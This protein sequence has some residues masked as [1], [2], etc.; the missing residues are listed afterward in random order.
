MKDCPYMSRQALFGNSVAVGEL[1][2]DLQDGVLLLQLLEIISNERLPR[3]SRGRLRV[4]KIEN[5]N[6]ALKFL[7][8]KRVKLESIGAEDIVDGNPRLT[9]GLIWTIILRFQIQD[10]KLEEEESNEKRSAKEALLIWCQRKTAGYRSCKVDNFTTSW[11]NGLAFNALIHAHRPDL[12]NYDRLNPSEHIH[13]LN[14]AFSVAQERLGISRLLDAED[15]DIAKPDEKSIMTYVAAYYH[16]FAKMKSEQTGSKRIAKIMDFQIEID[17]MKT[18]YER[19]VEALLEWISEKQEQLDSRQFPNTLEGVQRETTKFKQYR[20]IEKPPKYNERGLIE[21]QFFDI[22]TKLRANNQ[23]PYVPPEGRMLNDVEKAWQQLESSEHAREIALREETSRQERLQQLAEKFER[24]A[25]LRETYVKDMDRVLD[26]RYFVVKD[27]A[28]VEA[29]IKKHEAISADLLPRKER[30]TMLSQMAN[31][32]WQENYHRKEEVKG[33]E[34]SIVQRWSHLLQLVERRGQ[35]LANF[36]DLMDM[37]RE[38]ESITAEIKEIEGQ[39][40]SEDY[41]KHLFGVEDLLQK[42]QLMEAHVKSLGQRVDRVNIK[43]NGFISSQHAESA[44]IQKKLEDVNTNYDRLK[45]KSGIRRTKLEDGLNHYEFLRDTEEE[46]GWVM[47][48]QRIAKSVVTGKDLHSVLSQQQKH[49]ALEAEMA[50]RHPQLEAVCGRGQAL[51]DSKH[52]HRGEISLRVKGLQEKWDRLKDLAVS[53]RIRLEQAVLAHQY[54]TDGNEAESWMREK[55]PLVCSEDYGKDVQSAQSLLQRH[56]YLEEEIRAYESGI[57]KLGEQAQQMIDSGTMNQLQSTSSPSMN[58][59]LEEDQYL[60]E[61]VEVPYEVE[62]EKTVEREAVREVLEDRKVP[63]VKAMYKYSGKGMSVDRGQILVLTSKTNKDWWCV[64][65]PDGVE[66]YVPANYVKEV[67]GKVTSVHFDRDNLEERQQ[68]ISATYRRLVKLAQARRRY[69]EDS[70]QLFG[71]YRECDEFESWMQDQEKVMKSVESMKDNVEA[72]KRKFENLMTALAANTGRMKK[73]DQLADEFVKTGHSQ[74]KPVRAR[75]KELK[76]RWERLHQLQRDKEKL[77]EGASSIEL[78]ERTC[79]DTKEW[80]QEKFAALSNDDLGN[81]VKGVKA[82]QRQ[83]Q[84]L[85]RELG[86]VEDKISKL[87]LLATAVKTAHPS[88]NAPIALKEER[89]LNMWQQLK[90]KASLRKA[91]LAQSHDTQKFQEENKDLMS[92]LSSVKEQLKSEELARD[93]LHAEELIK[94]HQEL[95]D[96]IA[97]HQDSFKELQR[98]GERLLRKAPTNRDLRRKVELLKQEQQ[99]L[100]AAWNS[101]DEQLHDSHELQLFHREADQID[102]VTSS[103]EAFLEFDELGSTVDSVQ[104]L[105]KRHEEF[106]HTLQVQ[107]DRINSL[108]DIANKLLQAKHYAGRQ[109]DQK[110]NQVV[111]RRKKVKG[112]AKD[113]RAALQAS[114]TY[115]EFLRD[116]EELSQWIR[117][118]Y[119]A[120]TDESYRDLTNLQGKLQ[121]HEAFE[122]ELRANTER[123]DR[124]NQAGKALVAERHYARKEIQETLRDL[125]T[126][127]ADLYDRCVENMMYLLLISCIRHLAKNV[128]GLGPAQDRMDE[129]EVLL[130]VQDLGKDLRGARNL[131]KKHQELEQE[132]S[133]QAEKIQSISLQAPMLR[134]RGELED[135]V[136]LQEF[137]RDLD[138][139][140]RWIRDHMPAAT[141]TDYGK[142]L[143]AALKLQKKHQKLE[144][145]VTGHQPVI[146]KVLGEG[147]DLIEAQHY[148]VEEI[149]GKCEELSSAWAELVERSEERRAQLRLSVEGQQFLADA[150]EVESWVAEK[151]RLASSTDYGKD[152]D[153]AEK[154]I[155]K[156]KALE[157]DL[158]TYKGL[159]KQLQHK[160]QKLK[161][162]GHVN[163]K[164]IQDRHSNLDGQMKSL[165]TLMGDRSVHLEESKQLFA[166]A[167]ET[168]DLQE[169]I[170]EHLMMAASEDYGQDYEHLQVLLSKFED[171]KHK[172]G[173][174]QRRFQQCER[175]A[176]RLVEMN[177]SYS[178]AIQERQEGL[179]ESWTLLQE[180]TKAR[181]EKLVAAEEIHRFNR[182]AAEAMSRIQEKYAAI[183][184]D[185]GRDLNTVQS[186][187]RRHEGFEN[188]LVALEAQLQVL[189]D[190][191]ARLQ[192]LFP[193]GNAEQIAEQQEVL[194]SSWN[195]LQERTVQRREE[196]QQA[197]DFQKFLASVRDLLAWSGETTRDMLAEEAGRDVA[198]TDE[199]RRQHAQHKVEIDAREDSFGAIVQAGEMMMDAGHY[200]KDEIQE[201]VQQVVEEKGKLLQTW[202]DHRKHLDDAYNQQVFN[203]DAQQLDR[204]SSEQ[205]VH[206]RSS[207]LG[208]TVEQ[209]ERLIKRHEAFQKLLA[210][211][212]DKVVA[213][214]ELAARLLAEEHFD[215]TNIKDTLVRVMERRANVKEA[216]AERRRKLGDSMLYVLFNRDV[217]EVEGWISEKLQIASDESYRDSTSLQ[218]KMAKL[219][220]HQAFEAEITANRERINRIKKQGDQLVSK[221]HHASVEIKRR[222][223]AVLRAWQELLQASAARGKGL[224]EARDILEF[225]QQ[226]DQV[227]QWVKEK[228]LLVSAGELGRDYEHCL[229]L[230]KKL[231]DF[232]SD[233]TVDDARIKSVNK[234][235]DRLVL[236]A[237]LDTKD[238]L[239]KRKTMNERWTNLQEALKSYRVRLAGALEVHAFNRDCDDTND[240]IK[241]KAKAMSSEDYG[242]DLASV[243]SL[244]RRHEDMERDMTAIVA[245][246]E[247]LGTEAE[248]LVHKQPNMAEAIQQKQV[249]V[250]ENWEKLNDHAEARKEKLAASYQL[251]KFL[252]EFKDLNTWMS[253]MVGRMTSGELAKDVAGA[254]NMLELHNE[255]KVEIEGR[256]ESFKTLSTFGKTLISEGHYASNDIQLHLENLADAQAH[257]F[258]TWE[259]RNILL[260]QCYDLQMFHEYAEQGDTWLGGKEAF[261]HNEDV[262]D[263]LESVESLNRKHEGFEKTLETQIEKLEVLQ[264]FAG[265]LTEAGHYQSDK[266]Q[267][268]CKQVMERKEQLKQRASGRKKRLEESKALHQFLRN[269]Y[270]VLG[271]INEKMQT[272]LDECYRDPTNLQSKLQKH[273]A[274]EAELSANKGRV[275]GVKREGEDLIEAD[276]FAAAEIQ[277][278]VVEVETNWEKLTDATQVRRDRLQD[279]HQ[280]QQFFH[281]VDDLESWLGEVEVQLGSQDLG[282]DLIS[283]LE[284]EI[285][286]QQTKVE[287]ILASASAYRDKQHFLADNIQERATVITDR[288]NG[289][290]EPMQ[291]RRDNLEDTLVLQQFYRDVEDELAWVREKEPLATSTDLGQNLTSVQSLQKKHQA[292]EAE[293]SSHEPLIDAVLNTGQHL[294]GGEHYAAADI[295]YHLK[296]GTDINISCPVYQQ[297][298]AEVSEAESWM[299]DRRPLLTSTE[300][301]KD[302][303]SAQALLKKLDT[304]ERDLE[305]F[306]ST[307]DSLAVLAKS[308]VDKKHYAATKIK[309][310]QAQAQK[311]FAAL[312]ESAVRRRA[313]LVECH[314]LYQFYREADEVCAWI[315]EKGTVAASEDYGKDLEHVQI[316]QKKF[317]DFVQQVS[318]SE[319]RV[320]SV[321]DLGKALCDEQHTDAAAIIARCSE[322]NQ[323][324][325]ELKEMTQSRQEALDGARQV[326]TFDRDCEETKSWIHEKEM[327]LSSEDYGHDLA[328]VQAAVRRHEGVE[329]D[330]A[331]LG[332]QVDSINREASRLNTILPDARHHID[333]RREDVANVWNALLNSAL[334]RKDRLQQA[335]KLQLYFN[336]F[337]ELMAWTK[338]MK[339]IISRPEEAKDVSGV[340]AIIA[341]HVEHRAEIDG[342]LDNF[343]KFVQAGQALIDKGHFLAG[344]GDGLTDTVR[345][346]VERLNTALEGLLQLWEERRQTYENMLDAQMFKREAEQADAWLDLR[347]SVIAD[348]DYGDSVSAVEELLKKQEDFEKTLAAQEEKFSALNRLTMTEQRSEQHKANLA[349]LQKEEEQRKEQ[350]R[351][352]EMRKREQERI[353]EERRLEQERRRAREEQERKEREA[354]ERLVAEQNARLEAEANRLEQERNGQVTTV[355]EPN[356]TPVPTPVVAPR[357]PVQAPAPVVAPRTPVQVPA[358]VVAPRTPV[359]VPA[360]EE[361][362]ARGTPSHVTIPVAA[363]RTDVQVPMQVDAKRGPSQIPAQ[364]VAQDRRRAAP[365]APPKVHV[366]VASKVT[367]PPVSPREE[368]KEDMLDAA[369]PVEVELPSETVVASAAPMAAAAPPF[370]KTAKKED[371]QVVKV[372][373]L[374]NDSVRSVVSKKGEAGKK[375]PDMQ[376]ER[377]GTLERKQELQP[378][379]KRSTVR[380]WKSYYT[381]LSGPLLCFYKDQKDWTQSSTAGPSIQLQGATCEVAVDYHKKKH[382]FRLRPCDGSEYL[383][384]AKS[385]L[386]MR[387][388]ISKVQIQ[389]NLPPPAQQPNSLEPAS[390]KVRTPSS[391]SSESA[392]SSSTAPSSPP[393]SPP[394]KM[395]KPQAPKPPTW[396][397]YP[398]PTETPSPAFPEETSSPRQEK[399]LVKQEAVSD[400]PK[401]AASKDAEPQRKPALKKTRSDSPSRIPR[402]A[403]FS[404][405][406]RS[407]S[408]RSGSPRP[409]SRPSTPTRIPVPD[410]PSRPAPKLPIEKQSSSPAAVRPPMTTFRAGERVRLPSDT[411]SH[412]SVEGI[413]PIKASLIGTERTRFPSDTSSHSSAEG[414]PPASTPP[415]VRRLHSRGGDSPTSQATGS[416]IP[417]RKTGSP[418]GIRRPPGRQVGSLVANRAKAFQSGGM[419]QPGGAPTSPR[420]TFTPSTLRSASMDSETSNNSNGNSNGTDAVPHKGVPPPPHRVPPPPPQAPPPPPPAANNVQANFKACLDDL[421]QKVEDR[422]ARASSSSAENDISARLS[423]SSNARSSTSSTDNGATT[424]SSGTLQDPF[425]EVYTDD[426][427]AYDPSSLLQGPT[428][429]RDNSIPEDDLP[430]PPGPDKKMKPRQGPSKPGVIKAFQPIPEPKREGPSVVNKVKGLFESGALKLPFSSMASPSPPKQKAGFAKKTKVP[431]LNLQETDGQSSATPITP[432]SSHRSLLSPRDH[433]QLFNDNLNMAPTSLPGPTEQE[434]V[435]YTAV[436]GDLIQLDTPTNS[437]RPN[438]A[439]SPTMHHAKLV[440]ISDSDSTTHS[441]STPV[442]SPT[443][444]TAFEPIKLPPPKPLNR[445]IF[446]MFEEG[447]FMSGNG[448]LSKPGPAKHISSVRGKTKFSRAKSFEG[449]VLKDPDT[450][451]PSLAEKRQAVES[452]RPTEYLVTVSC[453]AAVLRRNLRQA[454]SEGDLLM[455]QALD[456]VSEFPPTSTASAISPTPTADASFTTSDT[457][458]SLFQAESYHTHSVHNATD[459]SQHKEQDSTESARWT[460]VHVSSPAFSVQNSAVS[461]SSP[462]AMHKE[463]SFTGQ[464]YGCSKADQEHSEE[465]DQHNKSIT[466]FNSPPLEEAAHPNRS[467]SDCP[468]VQSQLLWHH[469]KLITISPSPAD[470]PEQPV[471]DEATHS[472]GS[473][474]I[475]P[476]ESHDGVQMSPYSPTSPPLNTTP[477]Y[478]TP[479]ASEVTTSSSRQS[480][481]LPLFPASPPGSP[482]PGME[483][484]PMPSVQEYFNEP[485]FTL[486]SMEP[487]TFR[488]KPLTPDMHIP[489]VSGIRG[490][491]DNSVDTLLS[492]EKA[493]SPSIPTPPPSPIPSESDGEVFPITVHLED[494]CMESRIVPCPPT[495]PPTR[496]DGTGQEWTLHL[497]D[498]TLHLSSPPD[499]PTGPISS[500]KDPSLQHRTSSEGEDLIQFEDGPAE[501]A[502]DGSNTSAPPRQSSPVFVASAFLVLPLPN[503]EAPPLPD[504]EIPP[505]PDLPP[506]PPPLIPH[507]PR[508]GSTSSSGNS[509]DGVKKPSIPPPEPPGRPSAPPPDPPKR[510]AP[511]PPRRA[512]TT[513]LSENVT[514]T[515]PSTPPAQP[516][517]SAP[518]LQVRPGSSQEGSSDDTM[519]QMPQPLNTFQPRA[520]AQNAPQTTEPL[521]ISHNALPQN[522]AQGP[523]LIGPSVPNSQIVLPVA[524]PPPAP[525]PKDKK[526]VFGGLFSKKKK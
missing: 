432:T 272:A 267:Q 291:L 305:G 523:V 311:H 181:E 73:I 495:P 265:Q 412:S 474:T 448:G 229:E 393:T 115:Q 245:K 228:E 196:L 164:T 80:M 14:N 516:K 72:M 95:K 325:S 312:Q 165:E 171:L 53:R 183:P 525:K 77:L 363:K 317:A 259:E 445:S 156:H 66:G 468:L 243:E 485:D 284:A 415:S 263:S 257:L 85:E 222:V 336:D 282:K 260:A 135:S 96:D 357:T 343:E 507:H 274:F 464:Q 169:W 342:Q 303:Y 322:V 519:Q 262:G 64:K 194:V 413:P 375:R 117:E 447:G 215:S 160:A 138:E 11:S 166:Y 5:V 453:P 44:T 459:G 17:R 367:T 214:H 188:E 401:A 158:S 509:S 54:Y 49:K 389:A 211:Q 227:I 286:T 87:Q 32:L 515:P 147:Q 120:A 106:E 301:G 204:L 180:H 411:S 71:F 112:K 198:T 402:K 423:T 340:E 255:R 142:S 427:P 469:N 62:V 513:T 482:L 170:N 348:A 90:D 208:S 234:L 129:M 276:H 355:L 131:L 373:E 109:I 431:K 385:H 58:G 220:K 12:I 506:P 442:A 209:V 43:G 82:L 425:Q 472:A 440:Q 344:E 405:S 292:L 21:A 101:R 100:Q 281:Q 89:I 522:G 177:N 493:G 88:E 518:N 105:L 153:A 230:Q 327:Q 377:E 3:A 349:Q 56:G 300:Y 33:R 123:L 484:P 361:F 155:T 114:L 368:E 450:N 83:H 35:T 326:H 223:A 370:G 465:I 20:T 428:R 189:I 275:D 179:R 61:L 335:E 74:Q 328:S 197:L 185:L 333:S 380:A 149:D 288:F 34:D 467:T 150:N 99:N 167:R 437:P 294:I 137:L 269:T 76:E 497:D 79:D 290:S 526:G 237:K 212:E 455:S 295:R 351:L 409:G 477:T 231:D 345:E 233:L 176:T 182:D 492:K 392:R 278:K 232:G 378:N 476:K 119:K 173:Q 122:A 239:D 78:F 244:Q 46:E 249:E 118:K 145:E 434:S 289:L 4:H 81:S 140:M 266:V 397:R 195:A 501:S 136:R 253:D 366:P 75:Q 399:A 10:I 39:V 47:E 304:L 489:V 287:E 454:K 238:V 430:P 457:D 408:P 463:D 86:P 297:F 356:R 52:P 400:S 488:D 486:N 422:R 324:W 419:I 110:R 254:E 40:Q 31:E 143:D 313:R 504:T 321:S 2:K 221:N 456:S 125:N 41:G 319:K 69:L 9:L 128:K 6:K 18:D 394:A 241:E 421:V 159:V 471:T 350:Q 152:E 16:Y 310:K 383:F 93:V 330:L 496:Q 490:D 369:A 84:N 65:R 48:K 226:A 337:R 520:A 398:T 316:L 280:A 256:E 414:I 354:K 480:E 360:P 258:D 508:S 168:D 307:V 372:V 252:K 127:W 190:D 302:E 481:E 365:Q 429:R 381:V 200:A 379:G 184:D 178:P 332:V 420:R 29:A 483:T 37:F 438:D 296:H 236:Q 146:E 306:R 161:E 68:N 213:L 248:T 15:V 154:A 207:E 130:G 352:E 514:L 111:E 24:K 416:H 449:G 388:W 376:S 338:E 502:D 358:P 499:T 404:G 217:I 444:C 97:A 418:E 59:D 193:G 134:R 505:P 1:F 426:V 102:S 364:A 250:I 247:A 13:N 384:S 443:R 451:V 491:Q 133:Q 261:L 410:Q 395:V 293:I 308:L 107:G 192:A 55:M 315:R 511:P 218:D 63:Q 8:D 362:Q 283:Q 406:S 494:Y 475:S 309:Q 242:K 452:E 22:Q 279:A 318:N 346:K 94:Q 224:E 187:Q 240:R 403:S 202:E 461:P 339:A 417:I 273:Q 199:L 113:R 435:T 141:S 23:R 524:K 334:E 57:Q 441:D 116:V 424:D 174:G 517:R 98:L 216:A 498:V 298:Y 353:L 235:A 521:E 390:L 314:K 268:R 144:A 186:Q 92:W 25:L 148:A 203:R 205:E 299:N 407:A 38:M 50:A 341:R 219:K 60:E 91:Q 67:E 386:D 396:R 28:S 30:F 512:P 201:K 391:S 132:M 387:Q 251:Q 382:V 347:K 206:L 51:C 323:Q 473:V 500:S 359:Q 27:S 191:S 103:H 479:A 108:N 510:K 331:A 36:K 104:G 462:N 246:L 503:T 172:M 446:K 371:A 26:E 19:M 264:Q 487:V 285:G 121:K 329:R 320:T 139:E 157:V 433:V 70:I 42:H 470:Q 210:A 124:A 271:W 439:S 163:A 45:T 151:S 7:K 277:A 460:T 478:V 466:V 175:N 126:Q 458:E 270:E 374:P 225:T 162:A 436:M